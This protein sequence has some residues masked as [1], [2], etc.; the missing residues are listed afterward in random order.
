MTAFN[1]L[2]RRN[3]KLFFKDRG[4]FLTALISPL[5]L[6]FLFITF[7]GNVYRDAFLSG[8]PAEMSAPD[9]L[10][11][12]FV[13]GWLFSSLLAVSC[14][15]VAF[16][17]N[18]IMVQDKALGTRADLTIAPISNA[19]LAL[20]Y[21]VSTALSTLIICGVALMAGFGYIAN[22]GW[23]MSVS[24]V[25]LTLLDVFMLVMFGT[26]LSSVVSHFLSTQGQM[27]AVGAI[28]SSCYGFLCGAYM[29]ISQFSAGI[30]N[31]ISCLPGTYGTVLLRNHMMGGAM[32]ELDS[33]RLPPEAIQELRRAFDSDLFFFGSKVS[34]PM[35]YVVLCSAIMV[36]LAAFILLNIRN[37]KRV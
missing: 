36:L 23:Y 7:L 29:P 21:Y 30:R 22:A 8:I 20:S 26:L 27:S 13:G 16:C 4:M 15:T 9:K 31:L 5:I 6:L 19:K 1:A 12:G 3:V 25:L 34:I 32:R 35:L 14:V 37:R 17:S 24:E 2:V 10:V 28:M 11:D 18:L 33:L